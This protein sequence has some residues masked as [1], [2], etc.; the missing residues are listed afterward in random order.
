MEVK[1][2][3]QF[4]GGWLVGNFDSAIAKSKECEV[5][6]KFHNK[7]QRWPTHI[8]KIATEINYLIR[9]RMIVGGKELHAGHV[10]II[11]PYEKADPQFLEDCELIVIKMPSVPGDKYE[12]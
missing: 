3:S 5:C 4:Q 8:H 12:V 6:Y 10:F 9:G 7:G 1:H 2:I 11:R